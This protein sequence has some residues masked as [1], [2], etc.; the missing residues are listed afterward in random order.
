M[1][2]QR[3]AQFDEQNF[4]GAA[5]I[6]EEVI[7][8]DENLFGPNHRRGSDN[9]NEN[10]PSSSGREGGDEE[11][12]R[13]SSIHLMPQAISLDELRDAVPGA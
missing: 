12:G 7:F 4:G 9:S 10:A 3:Q 8:V 2:E 6:Q 1:I 13:R 11:M 5:G